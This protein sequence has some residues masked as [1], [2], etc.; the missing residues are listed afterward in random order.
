MLKYIRK[1]TLL[2]YAF[3]LIS[4]LILSAIFSIVAGQNVLSMPFGAIIVMALFMLSAF[5]VF[6]FTA[7]AADN[8][9]KALVSLFDDHCDPARLLEEGKSIVVRIK[10]P[11]NEWGCWFLGYYSLALL[12]QGEEEGARLCVDIMRQSIQASS[13]PED[14]FAMY[15]SLYPPVKALYG[16]EMAKKGLQEAE[17]L[18]SQMNKQP[19]GVEFIV[20]ATCLETAQDAADPETLAELYTQIFAQEGQPMRMR[21][22]AA[23][24][25]AQVYVDMEE[26]DKRKACLEFVIEQGNKLHLVDKAKKE[27][28]VL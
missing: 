15:L 14:S 6:R 11:C 19:E 18:L 10:P 13:S 25:A 27:L 16:S 2:S 28:N 12:D 1:Y 3:T 17:S 22:W 8:K 24:E 23:Y 4:T 5:V 26:L 21:V 7:K 9:A 20:W